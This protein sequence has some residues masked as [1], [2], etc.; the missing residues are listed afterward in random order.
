MINLFKKKN[1]YVYVNNKLFFDKKDFEAIYLMPKYNKT[2]K[3]KLIIQLNNINIP[4][5]FN[6]RNEAKEEMNRIIKEI[7][8]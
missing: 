1:K 8:S 6:S 3:T 2:K 4:I 5:Q 7:E